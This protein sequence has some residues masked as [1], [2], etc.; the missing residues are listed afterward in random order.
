[1]IIV[2]KL[3][4]MEAVWFAFNVNKDIFLHLIIKA[5]LVNVLQ[6]IAQH[7]MIHQIFIV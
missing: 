6:L 4:N 1:M 7:A 3:G 2:Y 5:A